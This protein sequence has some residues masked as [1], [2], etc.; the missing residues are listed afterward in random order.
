MRLNRLGFSQNTRYL[1][2]SDGRPMGKTARKE[3]MNFLFNGLK[4]NG[5]YHY[6]D[7]RD[8]AC[9]LWSTGG[10][11]QARA[12]W[13]VVPTPPARPLCHM[14]KESASAKPSGVV[15]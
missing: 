11:N 15:E 5:K 9:R 4:S 2:F 1:R 7:G 3:L 14:C 6:W 13:E 10:I 8:T 12:G